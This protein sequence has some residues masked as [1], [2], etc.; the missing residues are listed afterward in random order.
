M[1]NRDQRG[2]GGSPERFLAP[3]TDDENREPAAAGADT[4]PGWADQLWESPTESAGPGEDAPDERF[5]ETPWWE[6]APTP[7]DTEEEDAE[8]GEFMYRGVLYSGSAAEPQVPAEPDEDSDPVNLSVLAVMSEDEPPAPAGEEGTGEPPAET[9]WWT[10]GSAAE[11]TAE[12]ATDTGFA[13]ETPSEPAIFAA[14]AD[15]RPVPEP[16]SSPPDPVVSAIKSEDPPAAPAGEEETGEPPTETPWWTKGSAAEQTAEKTTDAGGAEEAPRES[17]VF[18]ATADDQ[19]IP[20]LASGP[21]HPAVPAAASEDP[22]AVSPVEKEEAD[23]PFVGSPPWWGGDSAPADEPVPEPKAPAWQ[24]AND[25][26]GPAD[27][28]V[29]TAMPEKQPVIPAAEKPKE[30]PRAA[31]TEDP[32]ADRTETA[33]WRPAPPAAGETLP[34]GRPADL[35]RSI[36]TEVCPSELVLVG[37]EQAPLPEWTPAAVTASRDDLARRSSEREPIN[38]SE[39]LRLAIVEHFMGLYE[40]ADAHL[41]EALPRSDRFGPA[42]N[43]LAVT[44]L[45]RGKIAPAVVYCKEALRETGGDDSVRAAASSN[46]GDLLR[47]QGDTREAVEAY[48]AAIGCLGAHGKPHWLARL[49]LRIGRL[50]RQLG[51][52]DNARQ[53]LSD[54]VRLFEDSGDEAGQIRSLV[55]LGSALTESGSHDLALRNFEEAVRICL[56]TGYK[57][58]AALVQDELGIAYM[59]QD[60]LTRALAYFESALT[61]Y[62]EL[63][64]HAREAATL[65]NIGKIHDARGD[66]D[67]ARRFYEAARAIN[68][69]QGNDIGQTAKRTHPEDDEPESA[70]A[71]LR[72]AEEIFSRAGSA[73]QLEEARRMTDRAR[74]GA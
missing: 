13:E 51:Q 50:Y 74:T 4:E 45:A 1:E 22:P 66:I 24:E 33:G 65:G 72:K 57:P 16:A 11:Q 53:H 52:A 7:V 17:S 49:H 15:D 46:L 32:A 58:G 43:A 10:R 3:D 36:V 54:S 60:Q 67:E 25:D 29:P 55:T 69:E 23:E 61:L 56:R 6:R 27:I 30:R 48:E 39:Y 71:K 31:A 5:L 8:A 44:S 9:P 62:R 38:A 42:L 73:E 59:A 63:G 35:I 18:A 20:G 70:Q 26:D 68:L 64:D 21:P 40:Q 41:K 12:K 37:E 14:T 19:P 34:E 28:S 47:L 2:G